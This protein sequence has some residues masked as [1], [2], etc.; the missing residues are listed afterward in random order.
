MICFVSSQIMAIS[1]FFSLSVRA[2]GSCEEVLRAY[3]DEDPLPLDVDVSD[4]ELIRERHV[5]LRKQLN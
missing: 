4:G 1:L 3:P 2:G 5:D